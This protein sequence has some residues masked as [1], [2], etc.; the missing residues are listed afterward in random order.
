[1]RPD[2]TLLQ[3]LRDRLGARG[4][5][6]VCVE[7]ECGACTVIVDGRPVDSC[8]YAAL[9]A[10]D[11]EVTT[12]EGLA[13]ADGAL[14]ALQRAF[15]EAGG[16]QCGF[17]TPGF[18]VMLMAFL[19]ANPHPTEAEIRSGISGNICRCTG[20]SQIVDAVVRAVEGPPV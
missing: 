13:G 18:L 7:G 20:Y 16:V 6:E 4:A 8:I 2:E 9:A 5:K 19:E 1:M 12:V 14:S 17:C 3:A 15:I 11:A 10:Q